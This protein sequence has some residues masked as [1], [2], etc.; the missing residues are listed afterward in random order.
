MATVALIG[1]GE[2]G[3]ALAPPLA[4]VHRVVAWS[5]PRPG[6]R[7][8]IT[9]AGAI[10]ATSLEEAVEDADAV[11]CALPAAVAP[12]V[13]LDVLRRIPR[14]A[15]LAD[16]ASSAPEEKQEA[17]G[18]AARAGVSYADAA[19][20]GTV[21]VS[22][23]SVSIVAAGDGAERLAALLRPAGMRIDV[24]TGEAGRAARLKLIRS[25]YMKGRD[26][27]VLEMML[28]ARCHG[29]EREVARSISGP[30]EEVPFPA[31]VE[32]VLTGLAVHAERRADEL[33]A[34][35]AVLREC[36]VKPIVTDAGR[37][38]LRDPVILGLRER[39]RGER[40]AS[41][42]TTLDAI[43]RAAAAP[44]RAERSDEAPSPPSPQRGA[45]PA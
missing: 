7:E 11:L 19:V 29:L 4:R 45:P 17:A 42:S 21:A 1:S 9:V 23:A 10:P 26:A 39:L 18:V 14:G 38:R 3:G 15:L 2:L 36:G 33:E 13:A 16:L 24:I 8:R 40:P 20:L 34:S 5:R 28:A 41:G 35:A 25:V 44:A 43:E 6:L 27:L 30:G 31:L 37:R 32:R 22:G 12:A